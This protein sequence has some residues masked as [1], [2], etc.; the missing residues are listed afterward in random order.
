MSLR[1]LFER[2]KIAFP[3]TFAKKQI[4]RCARDDSLLEGFS[5]SDLNM[6][7]MDAVIRR[8]GWSWDRGGLL[9]GPANRLPTERRRGW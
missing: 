8:G 2:E 1:R 9:C 4:P 5:K 6:P 7:E 3:W